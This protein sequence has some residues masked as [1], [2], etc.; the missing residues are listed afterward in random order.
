MKGK[1]PTMSSSHQP[2]SSRWANRSLLIWFGGSLLLLL[3]GATVPTYNKL[4]RFAQRI[5]AAAQRHSPSVL[6]TL[7][8]PAITF[9]GVEATAGH[10]GNLPHTARQGLTR[11]K[12]I[13]GW[14][15]AEGAG[16]A[17]PGSL[18]RWAH[19]ATGIL[20]LAFGLGLSVVVSAQL[21]RF[22]RRQP[23]RMPSAAVVVTPPNALSP[24]LA[25]AVVAGHVRDEQ[26]AA[27]LL[28]LAQRG[29]LRIIPTGKRSIQLRLRPPSVPHDAV[30]A[31]LW[32]ILTRAANAEGILTASAMA[33]V[34]RQWG[35]VREALRYELRQR[36][37]FAE[38]QHR[39]R[40]T[41]LRLSIIGLVGV[42]LA[43]PLTLATSSAWGWGGSGLCGVSVLF[44]V[45]GRERLR[46]TTDAGE[47]V[48]ALWRGVQAGIK[49]AQKHPELVLDLETILPYA[50]T[51]GCTAR[52]DRRLRVAAKAGWQPRWFVTTAETTDFYPYWRT[53]VTRF[54]AEDPNAGGAAVGA[55]A[56]S[57]F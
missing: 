21:L 51:L 31:A 38:E 46:E 20:L 33:S 35:P 3:A 34:R 6:T 41:L 9:H 57:S 12:I 29:A 45:L 28:D 13:D 1:Q 16:V 8:H 30:A 37:W 4:V 7:T 47:Q 15:D 55:G 14:A 17:V 54:L 11:H 24:A 39:Q 48:A 18:T 22:W 10:D 2:S 40:T 27:L 5:D 56:G 42:V 49:E 44:A 23:R 43:L 32:P 19:V 26:M 50:V 52:L 25:G 36:H 53:F